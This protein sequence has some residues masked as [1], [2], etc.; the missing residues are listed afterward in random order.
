MNNGKCVSPTKVIN[1][2]TV[3]KVKSPINA[4]QKSNNSDILTMIGLM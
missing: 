3:H 2:Q 1:Q 4:D